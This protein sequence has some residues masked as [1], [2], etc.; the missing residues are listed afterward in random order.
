VLTAPA[1][2]R[3]VA[4]FSIGTNDLTQYIMAADRLNPTVAK[5]NDVT[6]PAVMAAIELTAKAG[7]D[8][9][10]MVGMCGEAAG[11]PDLIPAFIAMGLTELSMSPSSIQR[12]K[13]CVL[14]GSKNA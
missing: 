1:L 10:I 2:A 6:H 9:G 11:R 4:F 3:E 13:K 5:L 8:A 14:D 7:V 12:A